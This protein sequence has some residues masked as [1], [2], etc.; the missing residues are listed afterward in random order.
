MLV[1]V[2][3]LTKPHG[4]KGDFIIESLTDFPD[5]RFAVGSKLQLSSGTLLT[6]TRM[7]DHSGRL[8]LHFEEV[9]DRTA[10]EQLVGE[11]LFAEVDETELPPVEGKFF[12][13]QLI[14]LLVAKQS[15]EVIGKVSSILHLPAQDLLAIDSFGKEILIP[16]VDPI[17]PVVDLTSGIITIDP[18]NGLLEVADEN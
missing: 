3:R 16:F 6:V 5:I 1:E 10:A 9:V 17:V 8:L 7:A 2:G 14:G 4:I 13:R 15:G 11:Y 12:D 18:P